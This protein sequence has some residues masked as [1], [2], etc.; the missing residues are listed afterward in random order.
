MHA[1]RAVILLSGGMDSATAAAIAKA[2]GYRLHALTVR[3]GQRHAVEL[4]AAQ[5]VGEALGVTDHRVIDVDLTVIGGSALTDTMAVPLDRTLDA[6]GHDVPVTYVPARNT[7]FLSLALGHAEVVGAFDIFIGAN[8]LDYSGYPDCRPEYLRAF[9]QL[10]NLAT[11]AGAEG[12]GQFR[13]HAP[14]LELSKR[15]IVERGMALGVD[16]SLTHTCYAPDAEGRACGR[17]D[18]CQLRLK[19]FREAGVADPVRYV[20]LVTRDS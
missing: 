2:D 13:I 20:G 14:L 17:C 8:A 16:F 4:R 15:Q 12:A 18:A 19:G 10:A 6:V 11:R 9:E 3:Y 7:V 5:R 1:S